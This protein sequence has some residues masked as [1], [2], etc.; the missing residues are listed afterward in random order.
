MR[1]TVGTWR[2]KSTGNNR[3]G[4]RYIPSKQIE[5]PDLTP[6]E[7]NSHSKHKYGKGERAAGTVLL[8]SM[9]SAPFSSPSH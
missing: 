4:R 8:S 3:Q 5:I 7:T 2:E 9:P 1:V 6:E